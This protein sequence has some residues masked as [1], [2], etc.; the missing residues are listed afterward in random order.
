M[1]ALVVFVVVL[2][3]MAKAGVTSLLYSFIRPIHH[4]NN[5][6]DPVVL[7]YPFSSFCYFVIHPWPMRTKLGVINQIDYVMDATYQRRA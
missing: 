3:Y 5:G 4:C 6:N 2:I 1:Y 7:I